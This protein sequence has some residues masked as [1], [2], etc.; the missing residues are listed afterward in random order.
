MISLGDK[1]GYTCRALSGIVLAGGRS[2]RMG[3]SKAE[4]TLGGRS[5]LQWQVDKLRALGIEDIMLSGS[6]FKNIP[7]TRT[8]PDGLTERGPLGGILACLRAARN[9][10]CLVLSVD[11]PLVPVSALSRLCL[12]HQECVTVLCHQG[13]QEPLIGIYDRSTADII[14][15]LIAEQGAPVRALERKVTWTVFD[16]TGPEEF[17]VNCNTPQDFQRVQKVY[18]EYLSVEQI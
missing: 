7:Y 12:S 9:D 4:L 11:T 14:F 1:C 16:Y 17:I 8:V 10:R 13:R 2:K 5:L 18:Q 6:G 15:A 3:R